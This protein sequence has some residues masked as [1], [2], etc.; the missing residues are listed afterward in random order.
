MIFKLLALNGWDIAGR[1]LRTNSLL[2]CISVVVISYLGFVS[3]AVLVLLVVVG[4]LRYL[5]LLTRIGSSAHWA[6]LRNLSEV[7]GL[8]RQ[9]VVLFITRLLAIV[10]FLFF[11]ND[12]LVASVLLVLLNLDL[13]LVL[14]LE[15]SCVAESS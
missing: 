6:L 9:G 1:P 2:L 5:E 13:D 7:C 15:L 11:L 3:F 14:V 8:L 10:I 12:E 4:R